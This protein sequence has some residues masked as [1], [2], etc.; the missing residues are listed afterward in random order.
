MGYDRVAEGLPNVYA[1]VEAI[2]AALDEYA[3]GKE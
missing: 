3:G 1:A 2:L